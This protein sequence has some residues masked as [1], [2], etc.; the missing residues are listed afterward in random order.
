MSSDNLGESPYDEIM[1]QAKAFLVLKLDT[2][3]P[4]EIGSFVSEFTSVASQYGKFVKERHPDLA[5]EA[6]IFVKQVKK[7]S[8]IVEM[9]PFLPTIFGSDGV[10]AT[11][12][13]INAINEFVRAYGGKLRTYSKKD[14]KIDDATRSDLRDFLGTVQA[15]ALDPDGKLSLES[16]VYQDGKRKQGAAFHFTTKEAVRAAHNIETHQRAIERRD[17]ADFE[18]V[19]MVFTQA[20]IKD[21]PVGKRTSERVKIEAIS[22][23]DLPLVYASALAEQRIKHEI[24]EA[25]ENVFKKG[26]VVDVNVE[27]IGGRPVAYR[28]T[29]LHQVIDLPD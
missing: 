11:I 18:R 1:G 9:I 2:K 29:N 20:N 25:D 15:V 14:G 3:N 19:L 17:N 6:H 28:V 27:T 12:E 26:F 23:R 7:G 24:Q 5:S 22:D 10:V 4:I 13:Q 21:T 8:I 16:A